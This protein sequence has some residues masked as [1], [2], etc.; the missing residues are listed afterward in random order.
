MKTQLHLVVPNGLNP[1]TADKLTQELKQNG[2]SAEVMPSFR[3][4]A[5]EKK[6]RV[7]DSISVEVSDDVE[8]IG[9]V[10]SVLD[11]RFKKVPVV[12]KSSVSGP[13]GSFFSYD[14]RTK[15]E[16][17]TVKP[18][19]TELCR[20]F[21]NDF[22]QEILDI[23]VRKK[24][25]FGIEVSGYAQG[26]IHMQEPWVDTVQK[27]SMADDRAGSVSFQN[28]KFVIFDFGTNLGRTLKEY[29]EKAEAVLQ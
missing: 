13:R 2:V 17:E 16:L 26:H 5:T 15:D 25:L 9:R 28:G 27:F 6:I 11:G 23:V 3:I 7:F 19:M 29:A 14:L 8:A 18:K 20:E 24:P 10:L 1:Q 21:F 22:N 12:F 4:I